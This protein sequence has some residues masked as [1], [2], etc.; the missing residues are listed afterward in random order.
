[1]SRRTVQQAL[2]SCCFGEG[3]ENLEHATDGHLLLQARLQCLPLP[4]HAR[5]GEWVLH[6]CRDLGPCG[7]DSCQ[8]GHPERDWSSGRLMVPILWT[9]STHSMRPWG[10]LQRTRVGGLLR[11]AWHWTTSSTSRTSSG[12]G[13]CGA[14]GWRTTSQDWVVPEKRGC[15]SPKSRLRHDHCSQPHGKDRWICTFPMGFRKADGQLG[16][17]CSA[18]FWRSQWTCNGWESPTTTTCQEALLGA[19]GQRQDY[20]RIYTL[21]LHC[22]WPPRRWLQDPSQRLWP[23]FGLICS[24]LC[25]FYMFDWNWYLSSWAVV[26]R[27]SHLEMSLWLCMANPQSP[28]LLVSNQSAFCHRTFWQ[29][30]FS[31][32]QTGKVSVFQAPLNIWVSIQS[33]NEFC[34][35]FL[36]PC[37]LYLHIVCAIH[38]PYICSC[39]TSPKTN[40]VYIILYNL[41]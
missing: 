8:R 9:S 15:A 14:H 2:C 10:C 13:R 18:L 40:C 20:G 1:M 6:H 41:T 21:Q 39:H 5:R 22:V 3:G 29:H 28:K 11:R 36:F 19:P 12:H 27:G 31:N 25:L 38:G 37:H 24:C 35:T 26:W 32:L 30:V 17:H 7:G 23:N 4:G 33:P 34:I 16:Q